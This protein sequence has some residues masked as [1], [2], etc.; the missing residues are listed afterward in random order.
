MQLMYSPSLLPR[1]ASLSSSEEM[2][3]PLA[4]VTALAAALSASA[5]LRASAI[6]LQPGNS[7]AQSTPQVT[8]NT[9]FFMVGASSQGPQSEARGRSSSKASAGTAMPNTNGA[10]RA[11]P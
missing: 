11:Q 4:S 7:A 10:A 2:A 6:C 1:A 9:T 3:G 8:V 5:A